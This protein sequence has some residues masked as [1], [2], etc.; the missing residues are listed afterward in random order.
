MTSS[1]QRYSSGPDKVEPGVDRLAD[2]PVARQRIILVLGTEGT[3]I[4]PEAMELLDVAGKIDGGQ[5]SQP[6][7][8]VAGSVCPFYGRRAELSGQVS[9]ISKPLQHRGISE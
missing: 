6:R 3:G 1:P 8:A 2:L 4:P 9:S 5:W 7:L